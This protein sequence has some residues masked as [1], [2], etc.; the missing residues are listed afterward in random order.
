MIEIAA[1]ILLLALFAI[2]TSA[3]YFNLFLK[4]LFPVIAILLAVD[5]AHEMGYIININQGQT[6]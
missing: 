6:P 4:I 5:T 2:W 3:D 1:S